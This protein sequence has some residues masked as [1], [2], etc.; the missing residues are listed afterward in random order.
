MTISKLK[1]RIDDLETKGSQEGG[2]AKQKPM[3]PRL[4]P[5]I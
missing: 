4:L 5:V 3:I 1:R 2:E